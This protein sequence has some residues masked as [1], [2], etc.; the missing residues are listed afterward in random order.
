[1]AGERTHISISV[2][3]SPRWVAKTTNKY[4]TSSPGG[5][6]GCR[7]A[8]VTPT[9]DMTTQINV[10]SLNTDI[11]SC[12]LPFSTAVH[13]RSSPTITTQQQATKA[14]CCRSKG[15]G[16][17]VLNGLA[18]VLLLVSS[19]ACLISFIAPQWLVYPDLYGPASSGWG[20]NNPPAAGGVVTTAGILI[21]LFY[22]S[23]EYCF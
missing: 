18:F 8:V 19:I 13:R 16:V 22:R 5:S 6:G 23:M 7:L 11:L 10:T 3:Q 21:V 9:F 17:S 15:G 1:M 20:S 4:Q 12:T 2:C 14:M